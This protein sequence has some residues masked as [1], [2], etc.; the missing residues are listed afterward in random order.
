VTSYTQAITDGLDLKI[1]AEDGV[2][3]ALSDGNMYIGLGGGV[4]STLSNLA[5]MLEVS[6]G[7]SP[8]QETILETLASDGLQ[9]DWNENGVPDVFKSLNSDGS[10]TL[11]Y[12][13]DEDNLADLSLTFDKD[14]NL[15][16]IASATNATASN[17]QQLLSNAQLADAVFQEVLNRTP[18]DNSYWTG[19]LDNGNYDA[20]SLRLAV[21]RGATGADVSHALEWLSSNYL[22]S[23]ND[24]YEYGIGADL[25]GRRILEG[26][27]PVPLL[28]ELFS[29]GFGMEHNYLS[30]LINSDESDD[31]SNWVSDMVT[32]I[33]QNGI[34][35]YIDGLDSL[36][37]YT[38]TP[39]SEGG[40]VTEP[41]IGWVAE[42][43]YD[44]AIIP[45]K[46]PNDPLNQKAVIRAIMTLSRENK[47]MKNILISILAKS[48]L[49]LNAQRGILNNTFKDDSDD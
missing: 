31:T 6:I 20:N 18:E 16:K 38:Y 3:Q 30:N 35:G 44:E 39:F 36:E 47:Q 17:T 12:D 41:R 25:I 46:D 43:G 10:I 40:I 23:D 19:E 49:Q 22:N 2:I 21:A 42:A 8:S 32:L 45:L 4:E 27:N 34:G 15:M 13:F 29:R 26:D 48:N 24:N 14:N 33:S 7:W 11:K 37:N 9:F 28:D 1:L 5:S